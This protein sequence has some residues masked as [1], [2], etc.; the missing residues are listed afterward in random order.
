MSG[1]YYGNTKS[2]LIVDDDPSVRALITDALKAG[3][4]F[5]TREVENGIQALEAFRKE[6]CD[7]VISDLKM[8]GMSGLELLRQ[9]KGLNPSTPVIIMTGYPTIDIS[10]SAMKEG[11][12]D[13]LTKP[14]IIENLIFKVN[15]YLKE[16]SI[17]TTEDLNIEKTN[18]NLNKKIRELATIDS[19]YEQ[20][21]KTQGNNDDIFQEIVM[22][23]L[24]ATGGEK[25]LLVFFDEAN[26]K[27]YKKIFQIKGG[28]SINKEAEGDAMVESLKGF[29]KK[30]ARK[31]D[32]LLLNSKEPN[33]LYGSLICAPLMIRNKV[34]ALITV[35]SK[36]TICFTRK[37]LSCI[38]N[39]TARASLNL[40]NKLLYES[41]FRS[42]IDTFE[43]LV[44]SIHERDHYTERHSRHV[45]KLAINTARA[46]NCS[47]REIESLKISSLL[48]DIGK[49]AIPD[50]ILLKPGCLTDEEYETIK[51]HPAT[52]ENIL[53]SVALFEDERKIIRHHHERW[54]GKG[55]PDGLSGEDI[56]F[57]SRILSVAD[58]FDAMTTDRP[59][60]KALSIEKATA[61]LQKNRNIQFDKNVV[62]AFMSIIPLEQSNP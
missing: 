22:L 10:V 16:R 11:A 25:C 50:H 49:I 42:I 30:V 14:F 41:L 46:M 4:Y 60:R 3:G 58:S 38:L 28:H 47:A 54:D 15:L 52:G 17:L 21:E 5:N 62:D 35:T 32:T 39:I 53:R 56:P 20:I 1:Q 55:Y 18:W 34:F 40:E 8:P 12:F 7:L 9:I 19:I 23:A 36:D 37:D 2:I 57:L 26:D 31:K 29:F 27:F 44:Q 13:F 48:H 61:E 33:S 6:P 51:N 43:S 59:Y 24:N 45:T